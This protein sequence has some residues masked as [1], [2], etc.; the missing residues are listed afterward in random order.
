MLILI[1]GLI[2]LVLSP[3][4]FE[5]VT[6]LGWLFLAEFVGA[7]I[8]AFGIYQGYRWGWVLGVLVA[9]GAFVLY[10]VD[11][12]FGLPGKEPEGM[13]GLLRPPGVAAKMVELLFLVLAV[14]A[15]AK[16]G[17]PA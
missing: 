4:H 3:E 13:E 16:R 2:H 11:G 1:S 10:F 9:G 6:Y 12:V 8:A 7:L 15:L 5:E 17:R 14:V